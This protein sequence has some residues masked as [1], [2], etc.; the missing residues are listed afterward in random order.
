MKN[1]P[2]IVAM[3][4]FT[5]F[6]LGVHA[7]DQTLE[8]VLDRYYETLGGKDLLESIKSLKI[9][10]EV[11][12]MGT[13]FPFLI[14]VKSNK[15]RMEYHMKGG[16]VIRVFDGQSGWEINTMMHNSKPQPLT[17]HDS[18]YMKE[19]AEGTSPLFDWKKKGH[20]VH[21]EGVVEEDDQKLVK[22]LLKSKHGQ[23]VYF[24]LN[25]EDMRP[26]FARRIEGQGQDYKIVFKSFHRSEAGMLFPKEIQVGE[27]HITYL[28]QQI[29]VAIEDRLFKAEGAV[30]QLAP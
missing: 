27:K 10:G 7:Q 5:S 24:F 14:L 16:S 9:K 19:L 17:C 8:E 4:I 20:E 29:N 3:L 15:A 28:D 22:I 13:Q 1:V 25:A 2:K 26:V 6:T 18:A 30:P 23:E 21:L 12:Y 11:E